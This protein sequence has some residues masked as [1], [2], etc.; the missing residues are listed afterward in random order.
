MNKLWS[1]KEN[2]KYRLSGTPHIQNVLSRPRFESD[3]RKLNI[4]ILIVQLKGHTIWPIMNSEQS[5]NSFAKFFVFAKTFDR[6]ARNSQVREV[7]TTHA[8]FA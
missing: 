7:T 4:C 6:S 5:K 2:K 8:V 1:D 3:R